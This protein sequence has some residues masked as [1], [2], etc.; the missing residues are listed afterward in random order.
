MSKVLTYGVPI[1]AAAAATLG[2]AW[3]SM[4]PLYRPG[5]VRAGKDVVEPLA[6]TAASGARWSI[7]PDIELHHFEE[8]SG[9]VVLTIH[10][11]PGCPTTRPWRA[12]A[13]LADR[14][15]LVYYHQRGCGQS[16]HP[17]TSMSGRSMYEN[18]RSLNRKLGLPAQVSDIERIRTILGVDKLILIGH[19][20]GADLAAFY[21]V[22]F[23]EHV[24]ALV[25]VAPADLIVMPNGD[26]DLFQTVRKR[27]PESLMAE[28]G[29]Y[30]AEYFDFNRAFQRTDAESS[31]FYARFGKFYGAAAGRG[32][33][34][35]SDGS[36]AGFVPL[37]IYCGMGRRYDFS[38]ALNGI[39]APVLVIHGAE[40][41]Q[42]E[43]VSKHFAS[44]F[45]GSRFVTIEGAGHFVF[46]DRPREFAT[47]VG[48]FLDS[49]G[50]QAKLD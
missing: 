41:L 17:I 43:S 8:G 13:L 44:Y 5:D 24:R 48:R 38:A 40:D 27:L 15:R 20:F 46:D 10:G 34:E 36:T 42:P 23:P 28:Y 37:A 12:G 19:S 9:A 45:T 7:A 21:A 26:G 3:Q 35:S 4:G 33:P 39:H 16:N 49:L 14:Y 25:F 47:E 31:A 22:E 50:K 18:M 6:P 11:G 2:Y 1:L 32:A 29:S 30:M